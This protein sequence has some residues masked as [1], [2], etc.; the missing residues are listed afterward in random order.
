[1]S[2]PSRTFEPTRSPCRG[3][4][5]AFVRGQSSSAGRIVFLDFSRDGTIMGFGFPKEWRQALVENEPEKFLLPGESDM[6]YHW[7]C[8]RLEAIDEEGDARARP[9]RLGDGRAQVRLSAVRAGL[10]RKPEEGLEPTTYRF[11]QG[12]CLPTE[13]LRPDRP[14]VAPAGGV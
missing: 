8:V 13:L 3:A 1:M 4:D 6:R 10:S 9:Q 7:A 12:G 2:P 14:I 5:E 11:L